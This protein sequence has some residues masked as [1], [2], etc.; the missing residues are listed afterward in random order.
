MLKDFTL[1]RWDF[2]IVPNELYND[3]K[4]FEEFFE[5]I[6]SFAKES[7]EWI[8]K[9]EPI[10]NLKN[11]YIAVKWQ[12]ENGFAKKLLIKRY[13]DGVIFLRAYAKLG[14]YNNESLKIDTP[15]KYLKSKFYLGYKEINTAEIE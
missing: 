3:K 5:L 6:N 1:Y 8:G 4:D 7:F 11:L 14:E 13:L 15:K 10:K 12:K 9:E 2:F